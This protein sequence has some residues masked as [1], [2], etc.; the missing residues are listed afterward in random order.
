MTEENYITEVNRLR[1][2]MVEIATRYLENA[3]EAEDITQDALLKLWSVREMHREP[4]MD[5]LAFTV[6]RHL[7]LK[8]LRRR[9]YRKGN[10]AIGVD[11]IDVAQEADDLHDVE[12]QERRLMMAVGKLPSKQRLLLRMR[13]INGKDVATIAKLTCSSEQN[14]N[15]ALSRARLA[16]YKYMSA[17]VVAVVC[18]AL[19]PML[20]D[21]DANKEVIADV[22]AKVEKSHEDESQAD[23]KQLLQP[24][25][26]N[27]NMAFAKHKKHATDAKHKKRATDAKCKKFTDDEVA[28]AEIQQYYQQVISESYKLVM[29]EQDANPDFDALCAYAYAQTAALSEEMTGQCSEETAYIENSTN[30]YDDF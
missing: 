11:L 15:K 23:V 21:Y 16:V 14:I 24:Q 1:S 9:E 25:A 6:L 20:W 10:L 18:L 7:C 28:F 5:R 8:E 13:Y 19:F 27:N 22:P 26:G 2:R 12:E 4:T 29:A 17:V 3:D 30:K